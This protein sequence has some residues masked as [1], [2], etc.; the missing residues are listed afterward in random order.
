MKFN[1]TGHAA[2]VLV[3]GLCAS[4]ALFPATHAAAQEAAQA[5]EQPAA[6]VGSATGVTAAPAQPTRLHPKKTASKS[7]KAERQAKA[8]KPAQ[9]ETAKA[10][11]L[12]PTQ[13]DTMSPAVAN[14]NAQWANEAKPTDTY[15]MS[16][17]AGTVLSQMGAQPEPQATAADSAHAEQVVA[18][19]QLNDLDRAAEE[20][21]PLTLAKATIDTPPA[22]IPSATVE[23]SKPWEQT[24]LIGK[25]FIALGGLLTLASAARMFIA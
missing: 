1:T 22:A 19:D 18:P 25:V 10:E 7:R 21:P 12:K 3:A 16:A 8:K 2:W 13:D 11:E 5:P 17:Q 6:A 23:N 4:A 20:Q 9:E 24:S 14:A 15:N